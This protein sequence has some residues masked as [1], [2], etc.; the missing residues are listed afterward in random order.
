MVICR[1]RAFRLALAL[2]NQKLNKWKDNLR[3]VLDSINRSKPDYKSQMNELI[4]FFTKPATT[5]IPQQQD[6]FYKYKI[7]DRVRI[8]LNKAERTALNF[9]YK[10]INRILWEKSS[11]VSCP[12]PGCHYK[13]LPGRE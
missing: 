7:G 2:L 8:N 11:R 12:Q 13:T 3:F 10:P 6:R 9:K 5:I 4:E 1:Q